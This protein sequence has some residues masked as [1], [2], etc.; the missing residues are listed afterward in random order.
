MRYDFLFDS[1]RQAIVKAAPNYVMRDDLVRLEGRLDDMLEA[2]SH[3][4]QALVAH[5]VVA[6]ARDLRRGE[7]RR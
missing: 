2:A 5:G 1:L 7:R 4:E 6:D 3:L